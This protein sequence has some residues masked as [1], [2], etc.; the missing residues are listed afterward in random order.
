MSLSFNEIKELIGKPGVKLEVLSQFGN[1]MGVGELV[2]VLDQPSVLIRHEDG[3]QHHHAASQTYHLVKPPLPE[4]PPAG[5]VVL[6]RDGDAWTH[7]A[8]D[9]RR[10]E[11]HGL[12]ADWDHLNNRYGPVVLMVPD[13]VASA[14]ELPF[15]LGSCERSAMVS[16]TEGGRV[17][18][19]IENEWYTPDE[20]DRIGYAILRAAREARAA[21]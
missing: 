6:D 5:S 10:W 9:D 17:S 18:L 2:G 11:C 16:A 13:P 4:E 1:V 3:T 21:S 12:E 7:K 19:A 8:G 20:A 14:P 15:A